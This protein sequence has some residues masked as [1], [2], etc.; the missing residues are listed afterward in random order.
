[1]LDT[2]SNSGFLS[3][4]R[5]EFVPRFL[6]VAWVVVGTERGGSGRG[7]EGRRGGEGGEEV[8]GRGVQKD[9]VGSVG[10]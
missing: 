5:V 6:V 2:G 10:Y 7:G 8:E 9:S 4:G 1:M 3:D